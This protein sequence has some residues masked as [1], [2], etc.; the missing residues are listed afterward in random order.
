MRMLRIIAAIFL[1]A[2]LVCTIFFDGVIGNIALLV[3]AILLIINIII[4]TPD[5][6]KRFMKK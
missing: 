5:Y 4:N 6:R 3:L 2:A 1:L